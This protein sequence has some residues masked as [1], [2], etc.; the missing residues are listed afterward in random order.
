MAKLAVISSTTAKPHTVKAN[1]WQGERSPA[2]VVKDPDSDSC[3]TD[4]RYGLALN[5]FDSP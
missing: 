3:E 1:S 5:H 2:G 4:L